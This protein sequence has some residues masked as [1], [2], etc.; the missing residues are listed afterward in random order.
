MVLS[1]Q[2][3]NNDVTLTC[4]FKPNSHDDHMKQ[5]NWATQ[6]NRPVGNLTSY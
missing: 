3:D 6:C 5:W 2:R 4:R 1:K